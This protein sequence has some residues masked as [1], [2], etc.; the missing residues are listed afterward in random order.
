VLL[1]LFAMTGSNRYFCNIYE[2][3]FNNIE[4][5]CICNFDGETSHRTS[6]Y[7]SQNETGDN[8]RLILVRYEMDGV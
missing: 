2:L 1:V 5:E 6:T 3:K 4:K 8:I 7:K